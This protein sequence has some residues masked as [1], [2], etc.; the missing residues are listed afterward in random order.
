MRTYGQFCPIARASEVLAERWT[1]IILRNLLLGCRTFNEIAAG[2]PLLSRTLLTK[3]LHELERAGVIEIS[4]KPDGRGC[5]Y[6]LTRAGRELGAVLHAMGQWA[7]K[8]MEV[9]FEHSDPDVVLWT[10]CQTFW[11]RDELPNERVVVRFD[12]RRGGRRVRLWLLV[13]DKEVEICRRRP[14]FE[15]DLIVSIEDPQVFAQWH[16]GLV[17]WS[18]ALRSGAVRVEGR[19]DL[20]RALPRWNAGPQAHAQVRK[21]K[22]YTPARVQAPRLG[23]VGPQPSPS[24]PPSS[25]RRGGSIPGFEGWVLTP[26]N[27]GYDEARAVWNG[28]ID[29][30]PAFIAGCRSPGDVAAAVRFAREGE[31]PVAVR[32]GGHGVAGTAVCDDGVV[33]DLSPM[34]AIQVD[35][36]ARTARAGAGVVWGEFDA[37]TQ[38]FGLATTGGQM[39]ETG[40]AGLTLGGGIGWL[41]RRHGLTVDNLL[42]ADVVLAD[43]R[44][45]TADEHEHA[46][47]FWALRGG[48]GNFGVVTSFTYALHR[49]GPEVVAGPVIWALEDAPEVLRFYREFAGRAPREVS[50]AVA[51]RKAPPLPFLPV[52]LHERPVC[53]VAMVYLGDVEQAE[54]ALAPMRR[55]GR[56][57]LDMVSPRPYAELQSMFDASVPHGWHYYW[58]S[59]ETGP[60]EEPI[61]DT[62]VE[63][64]WRIR[65]PWS[66]TVIFQLGG[67]VADIDEDA[68]AYSNRDGAH[69]VNING[70]WLP[71]EPVAAEETAWTR[72]FFAALKPYQRGAYVNFLDRD[73]DEERV[74]SAYGEKKYR[75]LA[76]LKDRYDPD[77]VFRLNHNIKPSSREPGAGAPGQ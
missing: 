34:K 59:A 50:T 47:L 40:I 9:T 19:R 27:E 7:D 76:A 16:L 62:I 32:G 18:K 56:P 41:M 70:V 39:S 22:G 33:I 77:N 61:I 58:K 72:R 21:R 11:R 31:L 75:R 14:G 48:G 23:V 65:S 53:M 46:D 45:V 4:P 5:V 52:E 35:P 49:V 64:S 1:P 36:D 26:A 12:F 25:R 24:A 10:W 67:A 15:E 8:W 13:E 28:A 51:L 55:F 73:D 57:L 30:R 66:Y 3:R 74:R 29:R 42:A 71:H 60:F 38:D 37:A 2:A 68:T 63:Y 54:R 20:A 44:V 69:N 17:E 43:G 6:E